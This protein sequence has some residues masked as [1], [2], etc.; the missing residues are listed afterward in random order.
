MERRMMMNVQA[1]TSAV[2]RLRLAKCMLLPIPVLTEA[3]ISAIIPT[4]KPSCNAVFIVL[5]M[6][7]DNIGNR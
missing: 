1:S 6:V 4:L 7:M 2:F 3:T 5:S